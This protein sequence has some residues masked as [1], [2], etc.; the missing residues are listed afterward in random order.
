ME[1]K[2]EKYI[3]KCTAH[4]TWKN[5][6][7]SKYMVPKSYVMVLVQIHPLLQLERFISQK[8]TYIFCLIVLQMLVSAVIPRGIHVRY[9]G[10]KLHG[11]FLW[12]ILIWFC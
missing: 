11:N 10:E 5:T 3:V 8:T 7:K 12:I 6:V 9:V 2:C 4:G 1:I